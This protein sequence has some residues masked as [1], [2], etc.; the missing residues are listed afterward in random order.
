MMADE[1]A[2]EAML[3]LLDRMEHAPWPS[4]KALAVEKPTLTPDRGADEG[5]R[6]TT[7]LTL[8]YRKG[9]APDDYWLLEERDGRID[10][11]LGLKRLKDMRDAILGMQRG[12]GDYAIGGESD[13]LWIW[14]HIPQPACS[15]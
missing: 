14:W 2:C 13:R 3:D 9:I 8:S 4:K 1:S 15:E 7:M 12:G 5:F 6:G 10:L 11:T